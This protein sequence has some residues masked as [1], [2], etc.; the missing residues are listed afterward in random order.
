MKMFKRRR[1][2][3][4]HF[5][6]V[7]I[8]LAVAIW[9]NIAYYF[10]NS[11]VCYANNT[12]VCSSIFT[13]IVVEV[14]AYLS[15]LILGLYIIYLIVIRE[16]KEKQVEYIEHAKHM[17][18]NVVVTTPNAPCNPRIKPNSINYSI[19]RTEQVKVKEPRFDK[20]VV[21][22]SD[23]P[24]VTTKT[25]DEKI[26]YYI[27]GRPF[28][29]LIN[30]G[31][32]YP[33]IFRHKTNDGKQLMIKYPMIKKNLSRDKESWFIVE[34]YSDLPKDTVYKIIKRSYD[35]VKR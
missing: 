23:F 9:L 15:I 19:E 14:L 3:Y 8:L 33:M 18:K 2:R 31:Y 5:I 30:H 4:Y 35:L 1:L 6:I 7:L 16:G 12:G 34:N 17:E 13:F 28:I 26:T 11:A 29:V 22:I 24:N 25:D 10:D 21:Y 27:A 32:Y 20:L